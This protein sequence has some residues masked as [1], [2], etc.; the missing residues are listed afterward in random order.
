VVSQALISSGKYGDALY[1]VIVQGPQSA[2]REAGMGTG[3]ALQVG[4]RQGRLYKENEAYQLVFDIEGTR[5]LLYSSNVGDQVL[6]DLIQVAESLAPIE[7][8]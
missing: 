2:L 8:K 4:S 6:D 5:I 1:A 7:T 3:T